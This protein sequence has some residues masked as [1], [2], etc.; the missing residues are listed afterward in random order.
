[1]KIQVERI[2][3]ARGHSYYWR[4]FRDREFD[5]PY[6]QHPELEVLWIVKSSGPALVGDG[7]TSYQPG[8]LYLFGPN[9]PHFFETRQTADGWAESYVAQW[10]A[11]WLGPDFWQTPENHDVQHLLTLAARG[12]RWRYQSQALDTV[13]QQLGELGQAKGPARLLGL[14]QI[15]VELT[16][17]PAPEILAGSGYLIPS[18]G[19]NSQRMEQALAFIHRQVHER[20]ELGEVAHAAGMSPT[21]FSRFFRQQ[22]GR[23]LTDYVLDLRLGEARRALVESDATVAEICYRVGFRNLSNFNAQFLARVGMPPRQFRQQQRAIVPT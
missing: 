13:R 16:T 20:I 4:H 3:R 10:K 18:G 21:G 15:L 11:D 7:V 12:L 14:Y 23:T 22:M 2:P 8:D 5:C 9:L 19:R 6:H 1:M 17:A